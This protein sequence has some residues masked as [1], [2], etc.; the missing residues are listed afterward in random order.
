MSVRR[1]AP[2]ELQPKEFA[3]T[4]KNLDWAKREV[5]KYPEGRQ[6]SAVIALLWRAQEQNG[7]LLPQKAIEYVAGMLGMANIRVL[8]VATFYTMFLLQPVGRKAHVQWCGTTPCLLGGGE[9]IK[10]V[11]ERR[12]AHDQFHVSADGDFSWEEVECLGAC[13]NAPMVLIG[14]DTYEDLTPES[15][16]K[17]LDAIARGET[18]KP[19]SQSGRQYSAPIGGDTTLLE[20]PQTLLDVPQPSTA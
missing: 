7:G 16:E 1:L 18:P 6:A 8:E 4:A 13:V 20:Q 3:F 12:I 15:F 19:G 17:V 5:T 10:K 14:S 9:E 11:C 2:P